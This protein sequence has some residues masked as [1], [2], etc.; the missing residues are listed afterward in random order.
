M[1]RIKWLGYFLLKSIAQR[2]GR[3]VI[4]SIAVMLF[5]ALFTAF[6]VLSGGMRQKM[7]KELQRYG[8]NMIITDKRGFPIDHKV[9]DEILD[10]SD[11]IK[12]HQ[13]HIY[14]T[15]RINGS[16]VEVIGMKRESL[17][18]AR[19]LGRFPTRANEIALG[20]RL[21]DAFGI[22][23]GDR[24]TD[25]KSGRS[26]LITGIFEKGTKED[27]SVIMDM[28]AAKGF[29]EID[30]VSALLL[31]VDTRYIDS[32]AGIIK[33]RF[34]SLRVKTIK[35]VAMAQQRLLHKIELLMLLVSVVVLFSA[36]VT[37]GSTVGANI[38]ER[39]EEIGLMK[40][41]GAVNTDVKS[42]FLSEALIFGT[43]GGISGWFVGVLVAEAVSKSAFNSLVGVNLMWFPAVLLFSVFISV[44]AA[45]LPVR[46]T[47]RLKPSQIL[48]GE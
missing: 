46:Q 15:I 10:V 14:G 16:T 25:E 39:M 29:F 37:L 13:E 45:Y 12:S 44:F 42:F 5:T 41:L 36:V 2:R 32:I 23:T 27:T 31:N 34:P 38:I 30:G 24:I 28:S 17:Q 43:V 1:A 8:A 6:V 19:L 21:Q 11:R 33:K 35:Q 7:D 20:R 22:K 4:S 47:T 3:F 26:F 40:A 9:L 48:R 18:G